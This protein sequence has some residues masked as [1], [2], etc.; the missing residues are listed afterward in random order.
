VQDFLQKIN[1]EAGA[2]VKR[3]A[4]LFTIEPEPYKLKLEQAQAAEVGAQAALTQAEAEYQRLAE[5]GTSGWRVSCGCGR[6]SH[7]LPRV[8]SAARAR[9]HPIL[10]TSFAFV[11]GKI[12]LVLATGAGPSARKPIGIT[13][14]SGML[15]FDLSRR[16]L[17]TVI[18][19]RRPRLRGMALDTQTPIRRTR[20]G[21]VE[22]RPPCL[23]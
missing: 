19:R 21:G 9:F 6:A 17:R 23:G 20:V 15:A 16:A 13:V 8:S 22:R 18:L 5:P 14:F 7:S 2:P 10:M 11:L 4:A 3:G 1:Y 12:P